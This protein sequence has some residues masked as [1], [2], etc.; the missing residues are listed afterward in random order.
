MELAHGTKIGYVKERDFTFIDE[1]ISEKQADTPS[2]VS[3]GRLTQRGIKLDWTK[4]GA[5]L[6]LPNNKRVAIPVRNN[7]P[8]ANQ[9]VLNIVK[10]A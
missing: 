3:L 1:S 10:V 4:N 7:C 2:I 6:V 9:E 8:Y 5:S